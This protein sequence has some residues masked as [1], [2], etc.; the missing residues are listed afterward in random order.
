MINYILNFEDIIVYWDLEEAAS[1]KYYVYLNNEPILETSKTHFTLRRV[2]C[3]TANVKVFTDKECASVFYENTFKM[4]QRS[5]L[6]DVTLSPYNA[7]GD[8]K[9]LNTK[10]IQKAIDDCGVGECVYIPKGTFL[11]GALRLHSDMELY[12]E[13]GGTLLGSENPDDYLPKIH[14]RFEGYE[15][16]CYSSL[17]NAG[18]LDNRDEISCRN[19]KVYGGGT[20]CGGGL[21]L[22][23][24]ALEVEKIR[25]KDY[26]ESLGDEI[27]TYENSDTIPG[28]AR[29]KLFNITCTDNVIIENIGIKNGS[30]WNVHMLYSK[31][32]VTAN[33]SFYSHGIWNSDGWDPDSSE[34]C[35]IFNCDF[36]TGDDCVAIKSGKNPE[37]NI[38]AK[39]CK[40]I[41]VFDCRC[42][43]AH[44]F[45]IGSEMSGGVEGV[46]IWDC[47][48]AN[49]I[50]G[51]EMK[52]T[53]KRGG[54]IKD[55]RVLR[56][57]V[58]RVL[59]HSVLYN[60]DGIGADTPPVFK[61]FTFEDMT[62]CGDA[63]EYGTY[64]RIPCDAIEI[65]GFDT[66]DFYVKNIKFKN[67]K[68]SNNHKQ[69][70]Q[71]QY[72][73]GLSFEN[74]SCI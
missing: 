30:C 46:Y 5:K 52:A 49:S 36:N 22:A 3:D 42:E 1:D 73:E 33:C 37:G 58:S 41:K 17:L 39:P 40:N 31:N 24:N 10:A 4:P 53:K 56:S 20:I 27:K 54:Y 11:S 32:I 65:V 51:I 19:I 26:M 72:C 59:I 63:L 8:G 13:E 70:I 29:P 55:V 12:I 57:V 2:G 47:D 7:V 16:D 44:G 74:I 62:I 38:I 60:D 23:K 68:I 34:N 28:R 67:I 43:T 71:L 14:S 45:A 6:I 18:T 69:K 21:A 35:T 64:N 15:M 61:D 50:Y 66:K 48:M 25:L 9:T